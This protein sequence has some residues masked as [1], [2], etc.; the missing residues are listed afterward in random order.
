M[1]SFRTL[2]GLLPV[3]GGLG[4]AGLLAPAA[5]AHHLADINGLA[6]TALNGLL[7]GLAHP[8]IGPDHLLFLLALAL[9]GL[10][11]RRIWMLA[12]LG[13]GLLGTAAGLL[14][15]ALPG[16]ESWL[17][18]TLV[19]E[20]L[21]ILGRM[22]AQLLIPAM[23]LHGYALSGPVLGWSAMPVGSYLLGLLLS[24]GGL[25]L[26]SLLLLSQAASR[27]NAPTRRWL[28]FALIG[29]GGLWAL[30]AAQF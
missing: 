29:L 30:A 24:Q 4:L 27:L 13:I 26:L 8:L 3:A 23:A 2:P 18:L 14:W 25:L 9:V 22:P 5:Q 20:A 15:P 28:A 1:H 19:L 21:I 6:P 10:Q 17:A 11:R 16:A 12:L 7:S